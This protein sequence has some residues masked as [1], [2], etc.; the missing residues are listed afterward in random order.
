MD[1]ELIRAPKIRAAEHGRSAETEHRPILE[2][3]IV[4]LRDLARDA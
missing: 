2:Q 3:Q 4:L 1:D